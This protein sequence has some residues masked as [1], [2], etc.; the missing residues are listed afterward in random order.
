MSVTPGKCLSFSHLARFPG[1]IRSALVVLER[2]DSLRGL[3]R[4]MEKVMP[5]A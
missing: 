3:G 2:P 5:M 4:G 1:Q